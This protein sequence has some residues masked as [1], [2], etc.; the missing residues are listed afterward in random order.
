MSSLPF[1][2]TPRP[3]RHDFGRWLCLLLVAVLVPCSFSQGTAQDPAPV[4]TPDPVPEAPAVPSAP[5]AP[6]SPDVRTPKPRKNTARKKARHSEEPELVRVGEP[7]QIPAGESRRSV[8]VIQ[9][10]ATIDGHVDEDVVVVGGNARIN[11]SVGGNVVS[12][13][14]GIQLGPGAE[15]AGDAVG[16]LG[17]IR[18]GENSVIQGNATGIV[19][20]VQRANGAVVHGEILDQSIPFPPFGGLE[21]G[22][23]GV[24]RWI[25]A[26]FRQ[27]ILKFRLLSLA[28][29]WVWV[30][31]ALFLG[32]YILIAFAAPRMVTSVGE[33]LRVRGAT[34]FLMGLL[35]LP[36]GAMVT[37]FLLVSGI[38]I[39][40]IP[41]LAAAFLLAAVAGKAGMLHH[42]GCVAFRKQRR[43]A[44]PA[45]AVLVGALLLSLLY[46]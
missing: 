2:R 6:A 16:V 17:G 44:T 11:G 21:N 1:L 45:A 29:G 31:A 40:V 23:S 30:V 26:T 4:A 20:G 24:P 3:A 12:V 15:I 41:F 5:D 7:V 46:L 25:E 28:V 10:S 32:L 19:G 8:V 42:L 37:L 33:T 34:A 13:G 39:L 14:G 22:N 38:G 18:M 36:L 9:S 35:A 43:D 27:V